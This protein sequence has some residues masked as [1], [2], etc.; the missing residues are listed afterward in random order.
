M[1][2][3]GP[4]Y[5]PY[6]TEDNQLGFKKSG[7]MEDVDNIDINKLIKDAADTYLNTYLKEEVDKAVGPAVIT[8]MDNRFKWT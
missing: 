4:C 3:V 6:L 1:G 7:D 2:P 8:A 5:I